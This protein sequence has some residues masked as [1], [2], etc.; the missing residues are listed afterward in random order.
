MEKTPQNTNP[1]SRY[2]RQPQLYISLPSAGRFYDDTVITK[3]ANGEHAVLPMTSM[4]EMAFKIP[5]ALMSGQS[6]VDV[7]RSCVPDIK[8]PWKL[9]NYDLDTVLIAIRIASYGETLDVTAG[10]P[11]TN[12]Q[13]SHSVSLPQML[14][15][16]RR[17]VITNE[18]VLT[19][20]LKIKVKPLTYKQ[21][22]EAQL[23]TFEQQ[24][25]Y[26][27][28][29]QSDMSAEEKT[30][31][32]SDSFKQLNMLNT[33]LLISNIDEITLPS[34]E[35]VSNADHIKDFIANA[36]AK[37]IKDLENKLIDIRQQG[38]I[39]PFRVDATEEQIKEGAPT[40][41]EVPITFDNANFFV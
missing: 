31:R 35:A 32:F 11:G 33:N 22:T 27:Q 12:E 21:V 37:I 40:S 41:Y 6:S 1:L 30:K 3:T 36:D 16:I 38:S 15:Q 25:I 28:I 10:V 24:R 14:D 17:H 13:A 19:D 39:K 20:G 2:F 7:I 5:D 4:D 29:N 34:G 8:D 26:S 18:C 9:V 23:K